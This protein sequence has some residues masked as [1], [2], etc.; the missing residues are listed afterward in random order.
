MPPFDDGHLL[1]GLAQGECERFPGLT[2]ADDDS[3]VVF[4]QLC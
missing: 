1:A 3:V 2:G 4:C